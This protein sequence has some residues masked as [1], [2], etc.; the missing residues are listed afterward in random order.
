LSVPPT[1]FAQC[2]LEWNSSPILT[3]V[4]E[5]DEAA[6]RGCSVWKVPLDGGNVE[7]PVPVRALSSCRV[8]SGIAEPPLPVRG[9]SKNLFGSGIVGVPLPVRDLSRRRLGS[10][11][12]EPSPP[13]AGFWTPLPPGFA[14]PPPAEAA[15]A[16]TKRLDKRIDTG[17]ALLIYVAPID[18]DTNSEGEPHVLCHRT[19]V[20]K[21]DHMESSRNRQLP[22]VFTSPT[23]PGYRQVEVVAYLGF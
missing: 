11:F 6:G 7:L 20:W 15:T 14:G 8:G 9:L 22:G 16:A 18:E 2:T 21:V 1:E 19:D 23:A 3:S 13:V 10:A 4:L 12:V 5:Q 17:S